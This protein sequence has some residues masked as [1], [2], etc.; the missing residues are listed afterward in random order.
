MYQ[1]LWPM[2][3][4]EHNHV[5]LSG[6]KLI[7]IQHWYHF[8][9]SC[10]WFYSLD[11]FQ[12]VPNTFLIWHGKRVQPP[13]KFKRQ[14][15]LLQYFD[16]GTNKLLMM[17]VVRGWGEWEGSN[18][19]TVWFITPSHKITIA[20]RVFSCT[21][22][23]LFYLGIRMQPSDWLNL[24]QIWSVLGL[25]STSHVSAAYQPILSEEHNGSHT[26]LLGY[27]HLHTTE[28]SWPT[29]I[30]PIPIHRK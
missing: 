27:Q 2:C 26:T 29:K 13:S 12:I 21:A 25:I 10:D 4:P 20:I 14:S 15:L 6:H 19:T 8:P 1:G 9:G 24:S 5:H 17:G 18:D 7:V 23:S 30:I 3:N 28:C 11:A 22:F 16:K